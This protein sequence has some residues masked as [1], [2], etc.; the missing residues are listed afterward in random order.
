MKIR[1]IQFTFILFSLSFISCRHYL[2]V[3]PKNVVQNADLFSSSKGMSVYLS[4]VYSQMPYEDFKY[5]PGGGFFHDWLVCPG[6]NEGSSIGRD[7][8][9]A[10]T[11]EAQGNW[12]FWSG[13]F[14][15]LRD[16]NRLI[17]T[18]P[19]YKSNYTETEY[20]HF[21]GEGYF[22]R[23]YLFYAFAKRYGGVPLI[24][25]VLK[26]PESPATELEVPRASEEETWNQALADMD[27]SIALLAETSP[28]RGM[29]NKYVALAFKSEAAL[30]AGSIAKYNTL[31]GFG[32]KTKVRVI[33]F[34][35]A[36]SVTAAN[37]YFTQAYTA[38]MAVIKSNKYDLYRKKWAAGDK[39]GQRQNMI[40]MFF[41]ASSLENIFV[42]DYKY[43][44][45][46]HGFDVYNI[47]RQLIG[48]GYSSGNCPTLEYVTLFDGIP[49]NPDGSVKTFDAN[50]KYI[51]YD[52]IT[53]LFK[54]AEPRLK[55]F[56]LLPGETF[57]GQTM[58]IRAGIY[59][60]STANG[61]APLRSVNGNVNYSLA[62]PVK[63]TETDAYRGVG[64]F[65][66]KVLF[67]SPQ[68]GDE[69]VTLPDNRKIAASGASGPFNDNATCAMTGFVVRKYQNENMPQNLVQEARSEQSFILMR[70][71]EVVLNLAEAAKE[72][73]LAGQPSPDGQNLT[74]VAYES[75]R[76]IRE[77]AGAD[78]MAGPADIAG[79]DGLE[80]IRKERKKELAFEHKILWDIRR[81]RIQTT[82]KINGQTQ[83]DGTNYSGLYP[84]YSTAANKYFFDAGPEIFRIR[85]RMTYPEYYFLI[86]GDQVS[87]SPVIDQQPGR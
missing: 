64:A 40:D 50:G 43:P 87:K 8:S 81:W 21:L 71:G 84:F 53:D 3:P 38:A 37:K 13:G 52:N 36:T 19:A 14:S 25:S 63:Y 70:L 54:N 58:D 24:K 23:G 16:I 73:E 30:Y 55:A 60:G 6:V 20:K 69:I 82:E 59:T 46:A 62:G 47:P 79:A 28:Q 75:V 26:Y 2:D 68:Q 66:S 9:G 80:L 18:L 35:P 33:G 56:V 5:S 17:E 86:P 41:D 78:P 45:L 83:E 12:N 1:Y 57:K 77:R 61:I 42:K 51:M 31:T 7:R 34:D 44:D 74:G 49:K 65:S 22:A 32:D 48:G 72:L 27:S 11:S 76:Q 15:V 85:F 39:D 29:V 4:R 67:V 10:M